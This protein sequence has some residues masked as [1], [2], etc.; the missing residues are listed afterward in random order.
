[1]T[2]LNQPRRARADDGVALAHHPRRRNNAAARHRYLAR[3]VAARERAAIEGQRLA[4]RDLHRRAGDRQ[5]TAQR[6][7]VGR[8]SEHA[9]AQLD[10]ATV[11]GG[12]GPAQDA[13]A[14]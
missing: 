3:D 6:D 4:V 10:H 11:G 14:H 2:D 13:A 8:Q 7:V 5:R 1:M 9:A 12:E